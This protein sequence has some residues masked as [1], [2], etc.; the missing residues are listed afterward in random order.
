M[1][2]ACV[3]PGTGA[4][5]GLPHVDPPGPDAGC[6]MG[7]LD[8]DRAQGLIRHVPG[9]GAAPGIAA[10]RHLEGVRSGAGDDVRAVGGAHESSPVLPHLR[11]PGP[12]ARPR[13]PTPG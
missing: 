9:A 1:A 10:D 13:R 6:P 7:W 3:D 2:L 12:E 8:S 11:R 4:A 5:A